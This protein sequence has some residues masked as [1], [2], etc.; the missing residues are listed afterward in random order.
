M[1]VVLTLCLLLSAPLSAQLAFLPESVDLG[2]IPVG[3]R[4]LT[5]VRLYNL[6]ASPVLVEGVTP[7][8]PSLS[9]P[10]P[11]VT[12]IVHWLAGMDSMA[13]PVSVMPGAPGP[14]VGRLQ[15]HGPSG[16]VSLLLQADA[17]NV[18]ISEVLA[19]PATG[20]AGDANGDGERQTYADEFVELHNSGP[21]SVDLGGWRLGDDDTADADWFVF[22]PTVLPPG[23][24]AVLFGG[25]VPAAM[26]A[27]TFIDDGRIGDGLANSGDRVLLL[28]AGGDTASVV[29]GSDWGHDRS[30]ARSSGDDPL[31]P[32]DGVAGVTELFSPG[33]AARVEKEAAVHAPGR[34]AATVLIVEILADPASGDAGDANGDGV[35]DTYAD[36][37]I[38][39]LSVVAVDVDIGGWSL[40][41][42]DTDD[43]GRFHFPSATM[44]PAGARLVL[45]GGGSPAAPWAFVDDGR[46]GNG[47]TN[48]GDVVT[49]RDAAG[50]TVD[51]VNG[52][53]WPA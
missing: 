36:E 49:L 4:R 45:F 35:R 51:S 27:P 46:I 9:L 47:L 48:S 37:F 17:V 7:M 30:L 16:S 43:A 52:S 28:T 24:F 11:P 12:D 41:D 3:T 32:H 44:L 25:G 8:D 2:Q 31:L 18:Y 29:D 33:R 19:D 14:L 13:F 40:G 42:D 53:A 6:G 20:S 39:L 10:A 5:T 15:A 50:D 1:R 23:G 21:Q 34:A 22:P 26:V 38:E